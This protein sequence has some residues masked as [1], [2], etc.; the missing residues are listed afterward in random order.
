MYVNSGESPAELQEIAKVV[1]D[2]VQRKFV[3][4]RNVKAI[5]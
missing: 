4:D 1:Y 5:L 2:A 3:T